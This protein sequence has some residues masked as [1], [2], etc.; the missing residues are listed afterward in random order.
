MTRQIRHERIERLLIARV[1]ELAHAL[2]SSGLPSESITRLLES[3]YVATTNAV[4][5]NLIT[6]EVADEIWR[7]AAERHPQVTLRRAA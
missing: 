1:E 2:E 5:L 3:A 7:R 4:A 6:A